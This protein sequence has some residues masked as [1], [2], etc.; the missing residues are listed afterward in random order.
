MASIKQKESS[1]VQSQTKELGGEAIATSFLKLTS[2]EAAIASGETVVEKSG[3]TEKKELLVK[4]AILANFPASISNSEYFTD[5]DAQ[6]IDYEKQHPWR[7]NKALYFLAFTSACS[8]AVQGMDET[9]AGGASLFYLKVFGIDSNSSRD[10]NLQGIVNSVPYLAASVIGCWVAI[11]SN[12]FFGRRVTIFWASFLASVSGLWQAF[13]PSWQMLL[14]GRVLMGVSIGTKSATVPVYTAESTP[15]VIRGGLVMLWQTL[16]AFGVMWGS[17]MG[18]AFLNAGKNN[19]RYMLGS[20]FPLPLVV[21]ALIFYA[22]ESPRWLISKGKYAEAYESFRRLR[23]TELIAARDFYYALSLIEI[24]K[25]AT[26]GNKWYSQYIQLFTVPRNRSAT[27]ASW[28]LMFGQQ[29]CGVNI[30]TFYISNVLSKAGFN[31]NDSLRGSVGFGALSCCGALTAIPL[32]DT[33]GRRFLLIFTFPLLFVF[34]L[35]TAFSFYGDTSKE[36]LG[37]VLTGIYLYVYFYGIG[38]G[39]VPFTYNA[40]ASSITV[41]DAHSSFGTATT[42]MFSFVLGFTFPNLLRLIGN[43]GVFCFYAGWCVLLY[44]LII[45]FVPE[46]KGFTLEE[47]DLVFGLPIEAHARFQVRETGRFFQRVVG[48]NVQEERLI[49]LALDYDRQLHKLDSA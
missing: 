41:R 3:L 38:A 36:R 31:D 6:Q 39:P 44:I 33:K 8:A 30:L 29:Y 2:V 18:C 32:I 1:E 17:V 45:L 16:T 19:W 37:L 5:E 4:G 40:E 46:T 24:E 49:D 42:W 11:P 27:L 7:Q 26:R 12:Y 22:P 34:L 48:K 15:A 9:A 28:L 21:C 43:V 47:L 10:A 23:N 14:A 20:I 13:S 25:E 35:W